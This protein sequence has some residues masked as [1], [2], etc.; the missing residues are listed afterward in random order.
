V[1]ASV[2]V[3]R[4]LTTDVNHAV[5]AGWLNGHFSAGHVVAAP[6]LL[7]AEVAGVIRRETRDALL[8][9]QVATALESHAQLRLVA[10]SAS[11]ARLAAHLAATLSLRGADAV[12]A[13]TAHRLRVPLISWDGQHINRAGAVVPTP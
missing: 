1:D 12:Y 6:T 8:A 7:I 9:Q 13:A 11:L 10:L 5:S 3:S 2:W 4:F